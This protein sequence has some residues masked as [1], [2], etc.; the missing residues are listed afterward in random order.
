MTGG[1]TPPLDVFNLANHKVNDTPC[2]HESLWPGEADAVANRHVHH[3]EPRAIRT[4]L[5]MGF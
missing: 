2:F 3:S 5:R 4:S 1:V